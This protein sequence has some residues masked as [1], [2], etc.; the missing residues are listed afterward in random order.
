ML[1]KHKLFK[2]VPLPKGKGN[3]FNNSITFFQHFICVL[4]AFSTAFSTWYTMLP[5]VFEAFLTKQ[6]Q[7]DTK[8]N[9][10]VKTSRSH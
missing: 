5:F 7:C 3:V 10:M 1:K 9:R 2:T 8:Q 4:Y 6:L